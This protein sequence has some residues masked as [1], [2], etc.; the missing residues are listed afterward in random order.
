[1]VWSN[2]MNPSSISQQFNWSHQLI[3]VFFVH[4][5]RFHS[6][7]DLEAIPTKSEGKETVFVGR[8]TVLFD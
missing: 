1:M 7:H 5:W 8:D 3:V 2:R 6:L 4:F